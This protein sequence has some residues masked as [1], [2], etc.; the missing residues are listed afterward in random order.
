MGSAQSTPQPT[1]AP[2]VL[3][4]RTRRAQHD[5]PSTTLD[6]KFDAVRIDHGGSSSKSPRGNIYSSDS[7]HV[8]EA[9]TQE[10]I[11]ELLKDPTNRLAY[12]TISKAN[13]NTVLEKQ[14]TIQKDIQLFNVKIVHEGAPITNQRSSGRCWIFAALNTFRIAIQQKYGIK[15]FELSQSYLF[16]YDKLEKANYFL[17]SIANTADD[18]VDSRLITALMASPVGDGGQWDMIVNLVSKYGIVPQELYPDSFNAMNSR[19]MDGLLTTK[20]REHALTLRKAVAMGKSKDDLSAQKEAMMQDVIRILTIC[21]GPPPRVDEKFSWNFYDSSNKLKSVSMT[22]IEFA[23]STHVKKFISLV[24]DPRNEYNRL[25]TVDH[26]GNVWDGRP[27]T[28]VNVDNTILKNACVAQIKKNLPVFFGSDVGAMGTDSARGIMDT[29]L[30]SYELGFNVTLNM[31]KAE[32]L[33]TGESQMTHAMVLTAVHLDENDKPVRW[34]VENSWS[35]AAGVDGY[36]VMSDAWFDQ[37]VYQ[38]VIDPNMVHK[39]V[40][41]VLK[42]EPKVLPLWDPMGAL[43]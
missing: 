20:L 38:A 27:I 17:T 24:N 15:S 22:P 2:R 19:P 21:L 3:P 11:K 25:L 6:E 43:A 23:E 34:R 42:Q 14:S 41:D 28:Y 18:A 12:S 10:Y 26:L 37:F 7:S 36:F 39:D 1:P 16:F 32:R 5:E 33:L 8:S 40:R 30:V 31:T 35:T 29:D 13:L 9:K 4:Q